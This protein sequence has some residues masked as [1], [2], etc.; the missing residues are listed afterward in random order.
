[1][2]NEF[3]VFISHTSEDKEAIARPLAEKLA[4]FGLNVWFDEFTLEVGDSLMESIDKGLANS[5]FGVVILS[6]SFLNKGWSKYELRGLVTREVGKGKVVLPIWHDISR[7]E[8]E[9]ISPTL[10]DKFALD[11]SKQKPDEIALLLI[12]VIRPDIFENLTR[13]VAWINLKRQAEWEYAPISELKPGPIRHPSLPDEIL[14]RVKIVHKILEDVIGLPLP[15]L[16]QSFQRDLHPQDEVR[17]WERIAAAYLDLT[18]HQE[19]SLEER[20]WMFSNLLSISL[21][22]K[23][24]LQQMVDSED[25]F[26]VSLIHAYTSG[27]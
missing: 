2:T 11:T 15:R 23:E 24:I 17:V 5:R 13:Y 8:I 26:I 16:I 9:N 21:Q 20:R 25:Q 3:D 12:K 18:S 19:L 27:L 4:N 6:P 7:Q 14:I 22:P 10:A 1:M